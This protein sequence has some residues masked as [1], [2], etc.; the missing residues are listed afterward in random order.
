MQDAKKI[1]R[2]AQALESAELVHRIRQGD[3]AA[4]AHFCERFHQPVLRM[5]LAST[6]DADRAEDVAQ[7]ALITVIIK[8][9]DQGIDRPERLKSYV[10]QTARFTLVGWMRQTRLTLFPSMDDHEEHREAPETAALQDEQREIVAGLI[11]RLDVERDR[12]VLRRSY[13]IGE[14]KPVVCDALAL[15]E[16]HFDRVISRAR[17]RFKRMA[18]SEGT[19]VCESLTPI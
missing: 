18:E 4:E 13:V 10:F 16:T 11:D 7:E 3:R 1:G 19:E 8:L 9:R 6:R 14:A 12:E 15:T 17:L 5:L 2:S